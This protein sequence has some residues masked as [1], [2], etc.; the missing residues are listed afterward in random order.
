MRANRVVQTPAVDGLIIY[1]TSHQAISACISEPTYQW[2][3]LQRD[4]MTER[5]FC[6]GVRSYNIGKWHDQ[7]VFTQINNIVQTLPGKDGLD[8]IG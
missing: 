8:L 6:T 2:R 4:A 1:E 7:R 5:P 3:N